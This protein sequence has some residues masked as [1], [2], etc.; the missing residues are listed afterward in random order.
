MSVCLALWESAPVLQKKK[1]FN[2]YDRSNIA[3]KLQLLR[4]LQ[5]CRERER[6]R[7]RQ[8]VLRTAT[9]PAWQKGKL[10]ALQRFGSQGP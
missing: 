3:E 8:S 6:E 4:P 10:R 5:Y 9:L 1:N 2:Y 7:E